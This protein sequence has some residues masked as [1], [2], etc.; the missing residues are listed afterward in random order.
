MTINFERAYENSHA[1]ESKKNF[2]KRFLSKLD[3]SKICID[4]QF[5]LYQSC[6][7][8]IQFKKYKIFIPKFLRSYQDSDKLMQ[9][10]LLQ[11]RAQ[12]G[13]AQPEPGYRFNLNL[14]SLTG[15]HLGLCQGGRDFYFQREANFLFACIF[16]EGQAVKLWLWMRSLTIVINLLFNNQKT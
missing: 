4:I 3:Y 16:S 2:F 7:L 12:L 1:L 5:D 13:Q 6:N 9:K 8:T 11:A 15:S 14:L 10:M